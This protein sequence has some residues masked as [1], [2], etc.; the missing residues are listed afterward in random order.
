[1]LYHSNTKEKDTLYRFSTN[2]LQYTFPLF[3]GRKG[4]GCSTPHHVNNTLAAL[5]DI[6]ISVVVFNSTDPEKNL[7]VAGNNTVEMVDV[8]SIREQSSLEVIAEFKHPGKVPTPLPVPCEQPEQAAQSGTFVIEEKEIETLVYLPF[9]KKTSFRTGGTGG[10][11]TIRRNTPEKKLPVI[12]QPS[13]QIKPTL[14][15]DGRKS[16][17][18]TDPH[19]II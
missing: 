13:P 8:E 6:E 10:T 17:N 12:I 3:Q 18:V 5:R 2:L 9:S 4:E 1:M 16:I 19:N 7:P 14:L 15:K 11:Y